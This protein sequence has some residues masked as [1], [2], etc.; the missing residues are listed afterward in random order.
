MLEM[1]PAEANGDQRLPGLAGELPGRKGRGPHAQDK[2]A[3]LLRSRLRG[4]F[5]GAQK[6][7]QEA[8]NRS[9]Q[10]GARTPDRVRGING[11]TAALEGEDQADG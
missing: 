4:L 11:Q 5:G 6:E 7:Q 10:T 3:K 2:I 1:N 8:G 9:G